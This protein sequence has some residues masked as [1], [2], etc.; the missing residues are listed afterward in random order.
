[1]ACTFGPAATTAGLGLQMFMMQRFQ[2][3]QADVKG[4]KGDDREGRVHKL[5]ASSTARELPPPA[6]HRPTMSG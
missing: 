1:M 4:M 2:Q 6:S 5:L 3:V